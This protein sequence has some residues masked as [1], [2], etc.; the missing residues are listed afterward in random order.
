M[1]EIWRI[2]GPLIIAKDMR[3]TQVYEVV[4]IGDEG[5]VGEI[6]GLE[7]DKAVIQAHEDTLGLRV[8]EVSS[9][10]NLLLKSIF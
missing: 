1:G 3:G 5:L 9:S 7:G 8:G 2:S 10:R 4:E 6:I